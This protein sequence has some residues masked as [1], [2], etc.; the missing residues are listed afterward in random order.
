MHL[1][2]LREVL[3]VRKWFAAMAL[4]SLTLATPVAAATSA[5]V[6]TDETYDKTG[7]YGQ[8]EFDDSALGVWCYVKSNKA[9]TRNTMVFERSQNCFQRGAWIV[10]GPRRY[11]A[12]DRECTALEVRH[13]E[14]FKNLTWPPVH[15]ATEVTP[16]ARDRPPGPITLFEVC[17][18]EDK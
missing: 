4:V 2:R 17:Q 6:W 18:E 5:A 8:P 10:V 16:V 13:A 7:K 14:Y 3:N 9:N 15:D 11:R 12:Q 1:F